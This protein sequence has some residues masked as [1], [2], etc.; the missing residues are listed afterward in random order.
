MV[1]GMYLAFKMNDEENNDP[2][3]DLISQARKHRANPSF[4]RDVIREVQLQGSEKTHKSVFAFFGS[5]QFIAVAAAV[6]F[7][8][9]A[10]SSLLNNPEPVVQVLPATS[11]LPQFTP[12]AVYSEVIDDRLGELEYVGELLAV[13]DPVLLSDAD[14]AMLLF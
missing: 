7:L 3:W 1:V 9:F 4:V 14:I 8:A 2:V 10:G 13:Q 11:S 5:R 6:A 12:E